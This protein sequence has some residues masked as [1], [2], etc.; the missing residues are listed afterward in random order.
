VKNAFEVGQIIKDKRLK[1]NLTQLD[2]SKKLFVSEKTVSRWEC[3]DGYPSMYIIDDICSILNISLNDLLGDKTDLPNEGELFEL[4]KRKRSNS[5]IGGKVLACFLSLLALIVAFIPIDVSEFGIN[6]SLVSYIFIPHQIN[7]FFILAI[8]VLFIVLGKLVFSLIDIVKSIKKIYNNNKN[9]IVS[10]FISFVCSISSLL[11]ELIPGSN[12]HMFGFISFFIF[13]LCFGIEIGLI[14]TYVSINNVDRKPLSKRY[15]IIAGIFSYILTIG[16][17]FSLLFLSLVIM[18]FGYQIVL[19]IVSFFFGIV[20]PLIFSYFIL[21]VV[22]AKKITII[23]FLSTFVVVLIAIFILSIFKIDFF[24]YTMDFLEYFG[25]AVSP[26]L[27]FCI[28]NRINTYKK[29]EKICWLI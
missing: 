22:K 21:S 19:K 7:G 2:L 12:L 20:L 14:F 6:Y 3:G 26:S 17:Y 10:L 28:L 13:L 23:S 27:S 25:I 1:M 24:Q 29:E 18:P 11:F 8:I 15:W 9:L 16:L 4:I 5:V